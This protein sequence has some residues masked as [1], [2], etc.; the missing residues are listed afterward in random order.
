M[1]LDAFAKSKK[2]DSAEKAEA[3]LTRLE[4]LYLDRK[5]KDLNRVAYNTVIEAW[6]RKYEN[7]EAVH[8][9]QGILL[10]MKAFYDQTRNPAFL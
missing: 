3:I 2:A 7:Q 9:A 5:L 6:G 10:Q 4:Q 8:R 1:C